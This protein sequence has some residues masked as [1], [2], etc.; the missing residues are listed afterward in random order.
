MI[1]PSISDISSTGIRF[2]PSIPEIRT[3]ESVIVIFLKILFT[4]KR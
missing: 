3:W 1:M 2:E 4:V